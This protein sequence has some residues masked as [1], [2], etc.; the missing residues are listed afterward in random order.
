MPRDTPRH[1]VGDT[2]QVRL[3]PSGVI[4]EAKIKAIVQQ[5]TGRK[6]QVTSGQLTALISPD[7][8]VDEG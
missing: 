6:Y 1:K 2:V 4:V 5:S 7:Q 3:Y 8:I